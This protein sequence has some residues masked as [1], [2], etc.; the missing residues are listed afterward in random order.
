MEPNDLLGMSLD[1]ISHRG[2]RP[3]KSGADR[4]GGG[5]GAGGNWAGN[6]Q[7]VPRGRDGGGGGGMRSEVSRPQPS[8][9]AGGGTFRSAI[10]FARAPQQVS[11]SAG[12]I[13]RS[14]IARGAR[15]SAAPYQRPTRATESVFD[16]LGED[17]VSGSCP[18]FSLPWRAAR[19]GGNGSLVFSIRHQWLRCTSRHGPF[20]L[21]RA[22]I[23][24]SLPLLALSLFYVQFTGASVFCG[25][26]FF[27]FYFF[28]AVDFFWLVVCFRVFAPIHEKHRSFLS[29]IFFVF[30]GSLVIVPGTPDHGRVASLFRSLLVK[31][32]CSR[33]VLLISYLNGIVKNLRCSL[34]VRRIRLVLLRVLFRSEFLV[35]DLA[36]NQPKMKALA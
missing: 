25:R 15:E 14:G 30:Q 11:S 21:L 22:E 17:F 4:G 10:A 27:C 16:R 29:I 8:V 19:G 9:V 26:A 34:A 32:I 36:K 28:F 2:I 12:P 23:L 31:V 18:L 6:R 13:R 20:V 7:G 3:N 35:S 1:Q 24:R 5:D 33:R